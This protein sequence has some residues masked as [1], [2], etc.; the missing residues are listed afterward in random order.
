MASKEAY[1]AP[2]RHHS[3]D[4]KNLGCGS[5]KKRLPGPWTNFQKSIDQYQSSLAL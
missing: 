5:R 2:P 1:V 3:L 4:L